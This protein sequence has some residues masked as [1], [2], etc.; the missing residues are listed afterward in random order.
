[1]WVDTATRKTTPVPVDFRDAQSVK[2]SPDGAYAAYHVI[3]P[4]G[5]MNVFKRPLAGGPAV[6]LTQD[7]EAISYPGWSRDGRRLALEIKRG[8][9]THIGVMPAD[10][11]PV[12]VASISCRARR[13][14]R[15]RADR[16]IG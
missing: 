3:Q 9:E 10:G 2:V 13:R 11:G 15:Q 8:N 16:S 6:Q 7:R 4:D 5:T 14:D 1:M 12:A